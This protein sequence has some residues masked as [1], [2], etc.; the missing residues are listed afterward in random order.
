[1]G[2]RVQDGPWHGVGCGLL[3]SAS[4]C[5]CPFHRICWPGDNFFS[6]FV[7]KRA[8]V[9]HQCA[10]PEG[11]VLARQRD[12]GRGHIWQPG[13]YLRQASRQA[14]VCFRAAPCPVPCLHCALEA[15][16]LSAARLLL[17]SYTRSHSGS[18][19]LRRVLSVLAPTLAGPES[20][21]KGSLLPEIGIASGSRVS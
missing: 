14:R 8:F 12:D 21:P 15:S 4:Q 11:S 18:A 9:R 5:A 16:L 7:G 19:G 17:G 6:S 3:R 2:A 10:Q 20:L 13:A 1:M